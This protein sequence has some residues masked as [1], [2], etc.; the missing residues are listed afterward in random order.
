MQELNRQRP[1]LTSLSALVVPSRSAFSFLFEGQKFPVV[2]VVFAARPALNN[3]AAVCS[4]ANKRNKTSTLI[5]H[6]YEQ[7]APRSLEGSLK[8][9]RRQSDPDPP[10]LPEW[11]V[12]CQRGA[13]KLQSGLQSLRPLCKTISGIQQQIALKF[14]SLFLW[15]INETQTQKKRRRRRRGR[16]YLQRAQAVAVKL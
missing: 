15:I 7:T 16:G 8:A 6:K 3:S 10:P 9:V 2:F 12:A 13:A 14:P 1:E 11:C 4:N 5:R